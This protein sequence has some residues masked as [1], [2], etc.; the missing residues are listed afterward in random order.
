[1]SKIKARQLLGGKIVRVE[2][3]IVSPQMLIEKIYPNGYKDGDVLV[4]SIIL[5]KTREK[6]QAKVYYNLQIGK[7]MN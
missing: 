1:M 7:A 3:R 5:A 4:T 2:T 6:E